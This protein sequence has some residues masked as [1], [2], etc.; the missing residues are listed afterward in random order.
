MAAREPCC[1]SVAFFMCN[2]CFRTRR[3][4]VLQ[5]AIKKMPTQYPCVGDAIGTISETITDAWWATMEIGDL[6]H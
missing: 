6:T 1:R 4:N 5:S 2:S 3:K